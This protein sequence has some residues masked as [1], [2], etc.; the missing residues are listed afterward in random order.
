MRTQRAAGKVLAS[1]CFRRFKGQTVKYVQW[2]KYLRTTVDSKLNLKL[3]QTVKSCTKGATAF[4]SSEETDKT[5]M[6]ILYRVFLESISSSSFV[7]CFET[8]LKQ[9]LAH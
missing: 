1:L 3:K 5:M 8:F 4:V 9:K 2:Y 7:S 6:T